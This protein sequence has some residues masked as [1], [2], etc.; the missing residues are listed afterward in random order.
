MRNSWGNRGR[1]ERPKIKSTTVSNMCVK[2]GKQNPNQLQTTTTPKVGMEK[3]A[4]VG[5]RGR[6]GE[7]EKNRGPRGGNRDSKI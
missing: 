1:G 2:G 4:R 7:R 5:E 6:E 3:K